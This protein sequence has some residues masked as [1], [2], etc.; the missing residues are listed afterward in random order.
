MSLAKKVLLGVLNLDS[1]V[2]QAESRWDQAYNEIHVP[3]SQECQQYAGK[4]RLRCVWRG[5]ISRAV[6]RRGGGYAPA[7]GV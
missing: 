1:A 6:Q 2:S 3:T 4:A 7:P 5:L